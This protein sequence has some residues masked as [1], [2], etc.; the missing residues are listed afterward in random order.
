MI[1]KICFTIDNDHDLIDG[2]C[3]VLAENKEAAM[4][5]F[6]QWI[7]LNV[8]SFYVLVDSRLTIEEYDFYDRE[9]GIFYQDFFM[10]RGS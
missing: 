4:E 2:H 8:P 9:Y 10:R 1:W 5:N 3:I 7:Y 6:K